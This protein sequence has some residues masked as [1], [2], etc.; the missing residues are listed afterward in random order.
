MDAWRDTTNGDIYI[1]NF[2]HLWKDSEGDIYVSA[3][4]DGLHVIHR[5]GSVT[6]YTSATGQVY[7]HA[8]D[9]RLP[10][11]T[12]GW[13]DSNGQFYPVSVDPMLP[14]SSI[15][16]SWKDAD[17]QLYVICSGDVLRIPEDGRGPIHGY[18]RSD[19]IDVSDAPIRVIGWKG[20]VPPGSVLSLQ[21]R[22]GTSEACWIEEFEG[23]SPI[24]VSASKPE[25]GDIRI[26]EGKLVIE[27]V[28][29]NIR[30][31]LETGQ[32]KGYFPVGSIVRVRMRGIG[33]GDGYHFVFLS[34]NL[35]D[36]RGGRA[37]DGEWQELILMTLHQPFHRLT[38]KPTQCERFEIDYIS[39]EMPEGW[40]EWV[41]ATNPEG[42][43]IPH[44]DADHPY[45]Q[46]RA[47]FSTENSS[48]LPTLQEVRLDSMTGMEYSTA[49]PGAIAL[50]QNYPNPFNVQT[51]IPYQL[52]TASR[53]RLEIF[54]VLGQRVRTLVSGQRSAGA[55]RVRWDG[56][57]REGKQVSSGVYLY[58]LQVASYQKLRKML[59]VR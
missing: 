11:T 43:V 48:A 37:K 23:A 54:D 26:E 34:V 25:I 50:E 28:P 17:G 24:Q 10:Y 39:I 45:L 36:D 14:F 6:L 42:S 31:F 1:S 52:Q 33:T 9:H 29:G 21:T 3:W 5:K 46:W 35:H 32:P 7:H 38:F 8:P 12:T 56:R 59:M 20:D 58:T 47:L 49:L 27:R 30:L 40:T 53:V 44:L 18:L 22:T 13:R 2:G 16:K 4:G 19:V 57:D 55:H 41:E 51:M 15:T